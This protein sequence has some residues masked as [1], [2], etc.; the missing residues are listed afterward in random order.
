MAHWAHDAVF[1]HIYPLGLCSAPYQNDF[2]APPAPRLSYLYS[3]LDHLEW[4]G[5]NAVYFGPLF[6]SSA[7]GYDTADYYHVDRRL[8]TNQTL[9]DMVKALHGRGIRVIL[10]GVFNHVGRDF[11]AFRDL[12]HNDWQSEYKDWFVG[13]DFD[14]RSK[15]GDPFSYESW[16]GHYSL[17]K[18]N[19]DHPGVREHL[20]NAVS[21]W[22]EWFD[23][24]GLRLDVADVLDLG[25]QQALAAH[26]KT[27][28]PEFWLMGEVIHGNYRNWVNDTTLNSVTNYTCYKGMFSSHNDA[29]YYEIAYELKRLYGDDGIYNGLWLYNFVDNHDVDRLAS[30]LHNPRH[31]NLVYLLLY[32]MPGIPSIYYGSEFGIYGKRHDG[33][34][35]DLRPALGHPADMGETPHPELALFIKKL[36]RFRHQFPALRY[37]DYRELYLEHKQFAF[38]RQY[39]GQTAITVLNSSAEPIEIDVTAPTFSGRMLDVISGS[40]LYRY[41]N[42]RIMVFLPPFSGRLLVS[43]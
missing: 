5:V 36:S 42:G 43:Q 33:S 20:L 13:V 22:V 24:D 30:A 40:D 21:K 26:T 15:Y 3:W 38:Q 16:E 14:Q 9:T 19:T 37:G 23:I 29:N 2:N 18:L 4:L 35:R 7:H 6:E 25:F 34:D 17:V 12:L 39:K 31:L 8:G 10:D 41:D 27:L 32:T 28:K 1:Y 11:W